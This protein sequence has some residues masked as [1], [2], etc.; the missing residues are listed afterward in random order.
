MVKKNTKE[1]AVTAK[2]AAPKLDGSAGK[3]AAGRA[4]NKALMDVAATLPVGDAKVL[5]ES[6]VGIEKCRANKRA[7]SKV[8]K[9]HKNRIK[10]LKID[11]RPVDE[12][13]KQRRMDKEERESY[14]LTVAAVKEQINMP[15]LSVERESLDTARA[16]REAQRKSLAE[17]TSSDDAGKEIGSGH[18]GK[19]GN[20]KKAIEPD[21]VSDEDEATVP[22]RNDALTAAVTH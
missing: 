22:A 2:K 10:A 11:L 21:A 14:V 5:L 4:A 19:N 1:K 20:G 16:G 13:L 15:L 17:L 12:V 6:I 8:E 7:E 3:R 9:G 18:I